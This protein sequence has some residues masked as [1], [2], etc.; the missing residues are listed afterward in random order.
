MGGLRKIS[1][2]SGERLAQLLHHE[3]SLDVDLVDVD[4]AEEVVVAVRQ[5]PR[6]RVLLVVE[7]L[8]DLKTNNWRSQ[9]RSLCEHK[10][11]TSNPNL[12]LARRKE[13]FVSKQLVRHHLV[14][15]QLVKRQLV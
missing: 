15:Q 7:N 10:I 5:E 8:A 2:K 13:Q 14:W 6:D 11:S 1:Q 9:C 3:T 12:Y 4:P